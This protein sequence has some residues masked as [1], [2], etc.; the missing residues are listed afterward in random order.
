MA[1]VSRYFRASKEKIKET[2][3]TLIKILPI[4]AF[5][6]PFLILYALFPANFE[7]TWKGRMFYIFFIW[8]ASLEVIMNWESLATKVKKLASA[9]NAIFIASLF[10]P[11]MYVIVSNFFGLNN[12]I[13]S[14]AQSS[15]VGW[16][17]DM[18]VSIEYLVFAALFVLLMWAEFGFAGLKNSAISSLF[19]A[20]IGIIFTIDSLYPYGSFTPFQAPVPAISSLAA[21]FFNLMG[22]KAT[23]SNSFYSGSW[24]TYLQVQNPRIP[25]NVY[26]N[27]VGFY[28]AWPC[29][30]IESLIIY[31]GTILV[32]LRASAFSLK[33]K[34]VYFSVGAIVT[35]FINVL[36][37]ATFVVLGMQFGDQS[38]QINDFHDLYG[39]LY[40][41]TWIVAYLLILMGSQTLWDKIDVG[42]SEKTIG[43]K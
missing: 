12:I 16:P 40:S 25:I 29:A 27:P 36:R 11:A 24:V 37:I 18:P 34:A 38:P 7:T 20:T 28:V 23:I 4:I 6:P 31:T 33:R 13:I 3:G 32:F 22:Y 26:T 21:S 14:W 2:L 41:I 30:G 9:R 15:N 8:L 19:L 39:S 35:Y 5:V 43:S 1:K 10:L 42:R 17:K